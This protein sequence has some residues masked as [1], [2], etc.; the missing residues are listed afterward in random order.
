VHFNIMHVKIQ[1]EDIILLLIDQINYDSNR[2][3]TGKNS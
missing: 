1:R 3:R 2:L